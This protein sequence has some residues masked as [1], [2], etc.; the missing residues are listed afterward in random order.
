MKKVVQKEYKTGTLTATAFYV[1]IGAVLHLLILGASIDWSS[2][3]TYAVVLGW[4][5]ILFVIVG[6][7]GLAAV[8]LAFLVIGIMHYVDVRKRQKA[9]QRAQT[10]KLKQ[11]AEGNDNAFADD[12]RTLN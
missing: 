4:P 12:T 11:W 8:A 2:A 7:F 1:G 9:R 6:A 3:W 10:E 5:V